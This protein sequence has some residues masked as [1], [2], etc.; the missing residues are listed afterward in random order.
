MPH[1][2]GVEV[3]GRLAPGLEPKDIIL[4]VIRAIGTGGG[5]GY[6]LEYYGP[7]IS[8]LS[9]E[10]RMTVCNMSIEAGARAGL[11]GPDETTFDYIAR[12]DRPFAPKGAALDA[13]IADWKTLRT[14]DPSAFDRRVT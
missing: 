10:G 14:E 5:T 12:G 13:A 4:A 1:S 2:G 6:V 8:A 7:A 9:M 11:I 3:T